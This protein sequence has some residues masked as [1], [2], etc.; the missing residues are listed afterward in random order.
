M[1]DNKN[2]KE[3]IF[4]VIIIVILLII[5]ILNNKYWKLGKTNRIEDNNQDIQLLEIN[6]ITY[7][8][9]YE[10]QWLD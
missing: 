5:S 1:K 6:N 2:K 7:N 3:L 8:V 4:Y 10:E 9:P